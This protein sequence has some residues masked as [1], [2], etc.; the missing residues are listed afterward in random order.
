MRTQDFDKLVTSVRQAGRMR[1]GD[2]RPGRAFHFRPE[3]VQAIRHRLAKSQV[4]FAHMIGVSAATLRN[5]EQG[6]RQ[7][8]GP[9]RALLRVAA[10][11]PKAVARAL[12]A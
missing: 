1:R 8:H 7:P 6:R 11:A 9:A 10:K 2:L 5:W 12:S 3:D 4:E